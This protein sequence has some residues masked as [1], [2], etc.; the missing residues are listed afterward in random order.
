MPDID[1]IYSQ[2]VAHSRETAMLGSIE[3]LLGWDERTL[4][5]VAAGEYRAEQ[6]TFLAGM[7]HR[8][9]TKPQVGEWLNELAGS[10]TDLHSDRGATV[11]ELKRRYDRE[12]KLPQALVE[13]LARTAVLGQQAWVTARA[14]NDFSAFKPL[15][16]KTFKL[17]RE[18]ATAIGYA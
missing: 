15:L 16:E 14:N 4:M 8:R 18:V 1:T 5:P 10:E 11:R 13:E 6:I 7:I 17:K 9:K 2:L 3:S 12:V